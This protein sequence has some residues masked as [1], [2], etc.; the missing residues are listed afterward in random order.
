MIF[1]CRLN[2]CQIGNMNHILNMIREEYY[3]FL[4]I[5][6]YH[7]IKNIVELLQ[8]IKSLVQVYKLYIRKYYLDYTEAVYYVL[9]S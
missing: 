4:A 6:I 2:F 3:D 1:E 9:G 8:F 7:K 5:S